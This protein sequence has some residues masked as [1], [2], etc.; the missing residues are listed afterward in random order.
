MSNPPMTLKRAIAQLAA[1][2]DTDIY[3]L[4]RLAFIIKNIMRRETAG[5]N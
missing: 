2:Q 5:L 3:E 1:T 4:V